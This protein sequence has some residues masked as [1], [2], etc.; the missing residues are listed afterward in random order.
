MAV[1]SA[2]PYA[3][4]QLAPDRQPCQHPTTQFFTG[5]MPFL[6]PNQQSQSTEGINSA[7]TSSTNFVELTDRH[8]HTH[9]T[10]S[11]AIRPACMHCGLKTQNSS[12][13]GLQCDRSCST[14]YHLPSLRSSSNGPSWYCV[15]RARGLHTADICS[16]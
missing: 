9:H 13:G 1:A 3:S 15:P 14:R 7:L 4:L 10:T 8:T 12:S 6:S 16:H 11:T 5:R 2:G